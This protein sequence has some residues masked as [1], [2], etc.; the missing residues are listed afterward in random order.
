MLRMF[1]LPDA[2]TLESLGEFL[3]LYFE[4]FKT[5]SDFSIKYRLQVRF[6]PF[7]FHF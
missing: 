1:T 3:L 7:L 4:S 2:N 5:P 6:F